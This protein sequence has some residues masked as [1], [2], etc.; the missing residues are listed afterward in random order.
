MSKVKIATQD[1]R[2]VVITHSLT[3]TLSLLQTAKYKFSII[4]VRSWISDLF[5]QILQGQKLRCSNIDILRAEIKV[6]QVR[7]ITLPN[8]DLFSTL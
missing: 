2:D 1:F 8:S 3:A 5:V 6:W 7:R 4:R